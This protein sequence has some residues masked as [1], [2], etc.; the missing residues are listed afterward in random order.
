MSVEP[1]SQEAQKIGKFNFSSKS[2]EIINQLLINDMKRTDLNWI[3][4]DE[5]GP[6]EMKGK[7]LNKAL[8]HMLKNKK[9]VPMNILLVIRKKLLDEVIN[10]YSIQDFDIITKEQLSSLK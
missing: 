6:L 9:N 8:I 7:G 1:G 3:V 5:I 2:F 10:H 4:I